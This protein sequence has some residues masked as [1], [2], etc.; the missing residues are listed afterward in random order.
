MFT[1]DGLAI[2]RA[3]G[4]ELVPYYFCLE[5]L[6]EDWS[7]LV[8][9]SKED[10]KLP[11]TPKVGQFYSFYSRIFLFIVHLQTRVRDFTE[12]MCLS[13]GLNTDTVPDIQCTFPLFRVC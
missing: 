11:S 12:V 8:S 13:K 3:N 6:K 1:A 7:K 2:K 10:G 5:D 4:K 9:H